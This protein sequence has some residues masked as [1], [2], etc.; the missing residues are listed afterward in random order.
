MSPTN[1]RMRSRGRPLHIPPATAFRP[2]LVQ[3]H[4]SLSGREL[5]SPAHCWPKSAR[6]GSSLWSDLDTAFK[7]AELINFCVITLHLSSIP[8]FSTAFS[9]LFQSYHIR[10]GKSSSS[11]A[12]IFLDYISQ[13]FLAVRLDIALIYNQNPE[14]RL[15][16]IG[17]L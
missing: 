1:S 14:F 17:V 6:L 15:Y 8:M 11:C 10:G 2:W 4:A 7:W 3:Q 5:L 16:G 12:E 13:L 9:V